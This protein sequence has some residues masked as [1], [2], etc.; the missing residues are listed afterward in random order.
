MNMQVSVVF[1]IKLLEIQRILTHTDDVRIRG[2]IWSQDQAQGYE[3]GQT[4]VD[5]YE[6]GYGYKDGYMDV[7]DG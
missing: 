4:Y 2:G 3:D 5:S 1:S 7:L 6:D